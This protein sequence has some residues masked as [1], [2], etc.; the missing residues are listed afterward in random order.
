MLENASEILQ[1]HH[2][3]SCPVTAQANI[4]SNCSLNAKQLAKIPSTSLLDRAA[5]CD[6]DIRRHC[7]FLKPRNMHWPHFEREAVEE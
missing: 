5:N 4:P 6:K 1:K 3:L 2:T 7:F